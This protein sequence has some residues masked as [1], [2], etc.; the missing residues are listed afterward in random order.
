MSKKGL[1]APGNGPYYTTV[2]ALLLPENG[3]F[4]SAALAPLLRG[5]APSAPPDWPYDSRKWA[6]VPHQIGSI[7]AGNGPHVGQ[8]G[9]KH[10][11]NQAAMWGNGSTP[12]VVAAQLGLLA[13]VP[14]VWPGFRAPHT[15]VPPQHP[16]PTG[17]YGPRKKLRFGPRVRFLVGHSIFLLV[18]FFLFFD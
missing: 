16:H 3:P 1:I 6:P 9:P 17:Q 11:G 4:V 8:E 18:D 12:R 2:L 5:M 7:V 10:W 15:V 13:R 14:W